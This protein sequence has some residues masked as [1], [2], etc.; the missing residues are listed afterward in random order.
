MRTLVVGPMQ[1]CPKVQM[2]DIVW[3]RCHCVQK[4]YQS[5]QNVHSHGANIDQMG[6]SHFAVYEN[7]NAHPCTCTYLS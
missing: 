5:S 4:M 3:M 2:P 7:V 1:L 6:D